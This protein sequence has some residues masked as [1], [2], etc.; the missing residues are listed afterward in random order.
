MYWC[1]MIFKEK[2]DCKTMYNP[3]FETFAFPYLST[4]PPLPKSRFIVAVNSSGIF[5]MDGRDRR[6]VELSYIEVK[7]VRKVR[8]G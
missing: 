7:E 2:K 4:G 8:Y 3:T 6:L 1:Q 5:F